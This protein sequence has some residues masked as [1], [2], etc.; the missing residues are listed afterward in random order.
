M[1]TGGRQQHGQLG[2]GP[3]SLNVPWISCVPI[4]SLSVAAALCQQGEILRQACLHTQR[5][6][7]GCSLSLLPARP[8]ISISRRKPPAAQPSLSAL[9]TASDPATKGLESCLCPSLPPGAR[10]AP[11]WKRLL[12]AMLPWGGA[13]SPVPGTAPSC[14]YFLI[15]ILIF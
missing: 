7:G 6:P 1:S 8:S 9:L 13:H 12:V 15:L 14:S 5:A 3:Q 2:F 10:T 11:S 4:S